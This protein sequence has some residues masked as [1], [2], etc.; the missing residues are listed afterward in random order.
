MQ[1]SSRIKVEF[2]CLIKNKLDKK[3][4]SGQ[5]ERVGNWIYEVKYLNTGTQEASVGGKR[6]TSKRK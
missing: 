5:G 1:G 2:S 4:C 3:R 6:S